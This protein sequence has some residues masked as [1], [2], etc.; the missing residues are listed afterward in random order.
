MKKVKLTPGQRAYIKSMSLYLDDMRQHTAN[1]M[2]EGRDLNREKVTVERR[3][4]NNKERV[5]LAGVQYND[6]KRALDKY[7][8]EI[9]LLLLAFLFMFSVKAQVVE[10]GV[11]YK[12]EVEATHVSGSDLILLAQYGDSLNKITLDSLFNAMGS[13]MKTRRYVLT[14]DAINFGN[15]APDTVFR[16][17]T[18][19]VTCIVNAVLYYKYGTSNYVGIPNFFLAGASTGTAYTYSNVSFAFEAT[20]NWTLTVAGFNNTPALDGEKI[21]AFFGSNSTG[22][23]GDGTITLYIQYIEFPK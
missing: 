7:R 19:K 18:S 5:H 4:K 16:P 23:P 1:I 21:L 14:P 15:T 9:G 13:R 20:N 6:A 11:M 3:L 8:K 12:D 17:D 2:S 22:T 10:G